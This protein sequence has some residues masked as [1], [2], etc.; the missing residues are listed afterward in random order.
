VRAGARML[1][2]V[3]R[4]RG[5]QVAACEHHPDNADNQEHSVPAGT[6]KHHRSE[7][8][9]KAAYEKA[10]AGGFRHVPRRVCLRPR[11]PESPVEP[12]LNNGCSSDVV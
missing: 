7:Q 9:P 11:L 5:C 3:A 2:P 12:G 6:E 4:N 1:T 8:A 10:L